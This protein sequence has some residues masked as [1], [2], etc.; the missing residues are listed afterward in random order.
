MH[1]RRAEHG[2][3]QRRADRSRH[4]RRAR[5]AGLYQSGR[6]LPTPR[7]REH[8]RRRRYP[9]RPDVRLVRRARGDRKEIPRT[10]RRDGVSARLA[11]RQEHHAENGRRTERRRKLVH[12]Q[13]GQQR[14]RRLSRGVFGSE[15]RFGGDSPHLGG[16]LRIL[17]LRVGHSQRRAR[18]RQL[19][20]FARRRGRERHDYGPDQRRGAVQGGVVF[21]GRDVWE[22]PYGGRPARATAGCA[23]A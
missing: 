14:V 4:R 5:R 17:E 23:R 3:L 9:G 12:V 15:T 6:L 8:L 18:A 19:R 7:V 10:R 16:H 22:Q 2:A 1:R 11:H 13:Q 21:Y 20:T